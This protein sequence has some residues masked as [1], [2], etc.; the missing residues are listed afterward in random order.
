MP[1]ATQIPVSEYLATSYRP[2]CDYIDGEVVERNVGERTHSRVQGLILAFLLRLEKELGIQVL[3][4]Q[5]VQVTSTRFRVPDVCALAADA[6]FE[7]IVTYPPLL[8]VE[9]LSK[10]D[11]MTQMQEKIDDYLSMG[12]R[13]VSVIDPRLRQGYLYTADGMH[14]AKDGILRAVN[15]GIAVPMAALFD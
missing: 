2:D 10:D 7:E 4:E 12:V 1:A 14:E 9:I 3:P 11:T 15:S 5:R 8:C 6:P 13:N